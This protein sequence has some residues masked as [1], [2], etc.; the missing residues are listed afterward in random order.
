MVIIFIIAELH[1]F[2]G[3]YENT[4]ATLFMWRQ[5]LDPELLESLPNPFFLASRSLFLTT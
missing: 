2:P 3:T 5:D 1:S 4:C